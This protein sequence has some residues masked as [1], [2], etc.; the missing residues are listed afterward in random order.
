MEGV[1][2]SVSI[3]TLHN[4]QDLV[5]Q[6]LAIL[7]NPTEANKAMVMKSPLEVVLSGGHI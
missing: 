7:W 1:I 5:V 3:L 2:N 6:T 4:S